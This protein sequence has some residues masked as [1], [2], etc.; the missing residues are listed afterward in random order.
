MGLRHGGD[1]PAEKKA[2]EVAPT[3]EMDA[4]LREC[5]HINP[6]DI[7]AEFVRIP[8]DLAYWN[9]R[10]ASAMRA[11]LHSKLDEKVLKANL[12]PAVRVALQA[13]GAKITEG[14]VTAGI[15]SD[16]SYIEAQRRTIDCEVEKNECYG[17][18]DAI[19]SKKEMLI[20]LGAHLRL[21]MASD[22]LI[23]EQMRGAHGHAG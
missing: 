2:K 9:S 5:L 11:H 7:Q 16:D 13:A 10:F 14:M 15:E 23:R 20:S 17:R 6:E 18:L 19:R 3:D 12:E 21:E 4:Y 22:P 8:G 1:E